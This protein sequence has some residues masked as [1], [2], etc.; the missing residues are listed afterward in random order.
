[1]LPCDGSSMEMPGVREKIF[2]RR[3]GTML[4]VRTGEMPEGARVF[5]KRNTP[6]LAVQPEAGRSM[7]AVSPPMLITVRVAPKKVGSS[8]PVTVGPGTAAL[9]T[10]T[11]FGVGVS[12]MTSRLPLM[13]ASTNAHEDVAARTA[14]ATSAIFELCMSDPPGH[15]LNGPP[16]MVGRRG[17]QYRTRGV[18]AIKNLCC[19]D[20]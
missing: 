15:C 10:N 17:G 18:S 1:M 16:W 20:I 6:P 4:A 13:G 11:I 12:R 14:V 7:L 9:D 3:P 5:R 19:A 2:R 8:D